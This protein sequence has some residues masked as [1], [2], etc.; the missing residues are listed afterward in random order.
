MDR[1]ICPECK[2]PAVSA[3]KTRIDARTIGSR[4]AVVGSKAGFIAATV[5]AFIWAGFWA[6]LVL[7]TESTAGEI[8]FVLSIAAMGPVAW[9]RVLREDR[10]R[11]PVPGT[12]YKC[13]K[14]KFWWTVREAGQEQPSATVLQSSM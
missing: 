10:G 1:W 13:A 8:A 7:F 2:E 12:V 11:D 4:G 3:K 5:L 6:S 14:C 9:W